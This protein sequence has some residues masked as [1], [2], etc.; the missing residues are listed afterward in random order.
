MHPRNSLEPT[1]ADLP[2]PERTPRLLV[3]FARNTLVAPAVVLVHLAIRTIRDAHIADLVPDLHPAL[4]ARRDREEAA[5]QPV[6]AGRDE[7]A[8]E[9]VEVVDVGCAGG[10]G[11]A[12]CADEADDV[13]EDAA[14]VGRV[15]A[16]VEAEGEVVG[17]G[18]AG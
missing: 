1:A 2:L 10:D 18:F 8:A 7:E 15:A 4:R 13:D 16:P 5:Q 17:G 6:R 11:L 14:D 3:R 12:D 9:E